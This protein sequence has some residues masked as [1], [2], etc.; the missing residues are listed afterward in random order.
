VSE[1]LFMTVDI[2][3]YAPNNN[4][5]VNNG[6]QIRRWFHKIIILYYDIIILNHFV[7][8]AYNIQYSNML[9]RFIA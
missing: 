6:L 2:Y 3:R 9:Y 1:I 8:V 7:T 5:A 4:V